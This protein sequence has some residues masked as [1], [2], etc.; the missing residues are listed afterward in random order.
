MTARLRMPS[1]RTIEVGAVVATYIL[2]LIVGVYSGQTTMNVDL[3]SPPDGAE[4]RSSPVE[5][6]ARVTIRGV[7]L[8]NVT[9]R[10]TVTVLENGSNRD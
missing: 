10:F 7:P 4:L 3:I 8:A 6:I 9:T 5:L 2:F 1:R